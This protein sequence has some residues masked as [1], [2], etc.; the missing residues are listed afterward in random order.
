MI[1]LNIHEGYPL[2]G[3]V[4]KIDRGNVFCT[5]CWYEVRMAND[6]YELTGEIKKFRGGQLRFVE[7][8]K[9]EQP[10]R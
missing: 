9:Y 4:L 3:F 6:N 8:I 5:G 1:Q 7:E 10:V 2:K